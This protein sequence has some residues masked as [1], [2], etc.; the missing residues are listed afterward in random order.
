ML[1]FYE[2]SFPVAWILFLLYWQIKAV[3]TKTTQ[4]LEPGASR[5]LR[6]FIFVIAIALL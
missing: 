4:R 5:I 1:W 3:N 6:V 2:Y